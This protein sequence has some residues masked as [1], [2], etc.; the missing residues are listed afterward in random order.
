MQIQY[1]FGIAGLLTAM[2]FTVFGFAFQDEN[3]SKRINYEPFIDEYRRMIPD[4]MKRE[5]IPG[6][7]VAIVDKSGIIWTEGFGFTD[8]QRNIPITMDTIFSIQSI[9]K[10][11]TATA[12]LHGVQEGLLD[13]DVPIKTYLPDFSV[14]SRFEE[15]PFSIITLRHLLSHRAGFTHEAPVGNNYGADFDCPL[16]K[17]HPA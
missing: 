10:T 8:E 12:I 17:L 2:I 14:H 11:F 1:R 5:K 13:L 3:S 7:S 4:V 16:E 9:S 15:D 6:V